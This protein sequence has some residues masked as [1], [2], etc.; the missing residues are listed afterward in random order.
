LENY[1]L[2]NADNPPLWRDEKSYTSYHQPV[3][4]HSMTEITVTE[5]SVTDQGILLN[6]DNPPLW[7]DEKLSICH[8]CGGRNPILRTPPVFDGTPLS[9]RGEKF[10]AIMLQIYKK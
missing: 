4:D 10:T 9:L 6:A 8:S 2:L 1:I 7:R 3:M 5:W